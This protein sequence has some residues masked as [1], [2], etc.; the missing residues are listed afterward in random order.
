MTP[1]D[2]RCGTCKWWKCARGAFLIGNC[3][4]P[5][6]FSAH[7]ED[8]DATCESEGRR[9]PCWAKKESK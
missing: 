1:D 2:R 7:F 3:H 5:V 8:K 9:C 4:A 6:P